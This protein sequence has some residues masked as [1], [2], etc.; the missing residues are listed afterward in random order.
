MAS[1]FVQQN[2]DARDFSEDVLE[3]AAVVELLGGYL[4]GPVGRELLAGLRPRTLAGDI[5]RDLELVREAREYAREIGRPSL[6]A[7]ADPRTILA[8]LGIEGLAL[9]AHEI[10]ALLEL[11]RTARDLRG[12]FRETPFRSLDALAGSLADFRS[13]VASLDGKIL[14]DGTL[15]SSASP[16]LGRLRRAIERL[17]HEVQATLEKLLRRLAQDEVVQDAVVTLRNDRF[18]I[19]IRTE[20]KRRVSGVVHGASSSGATVFIEP[21]ETLPLNNELVELQD[22]ELAEIAR[23]LGEFTRLLAARRAEL[24][25]ATRILSELDLAFAKAEFA[26]AYDCCLPEFVSERALYLKDVRHPLLERTLRARHR[27]PV[28]LTLELAAPKTQMIISG[29]NTGGKTVAVKTVG[30][31]VLMAQAALPVPSSEARLPIFGRVLADIGDQQSIEANL[32]T[33]SAHVRN[34]Q[35]MVEAAEADDLVLLDEIGASTEP[36]EGAALAVSILEHFREKRAM[37]FVTTH[38]SR[39]KAYAAENPETVNAAMEFDE[40]T[41]EPTYRLL[42]GLPGKSS[43]IDTAERLGLDR[44]IVARARDLLD[45]LDAE[46]AALVASLHQQKTDLDQ[47]AASLSREHEKL[48]TE[49][50]QM[51]EQFTRERR[52]RLAELDARLES[53]LREYNAKWEMRLAEIRKV[54][55]ASA[56]VEQAIKKTERKAPQLAQE[57]RESWNEQVLDALGAPAEEEPGT[58]RAPAVGDRVRVSK[59]STPGRIVSLVGDNEVEVEVGRIRMRVPRNEIRVLAKETPA[60]KHLHRQRGPASQL[61]EPVPEAPAEINVIGTTAEEARE[62]VDKFLDDAYLA[63]RFRLRVVHGHGKGILRKSLHEMFAAH[64]H[65]EKFY[66]A[67]QSEG[68][69]G[70]TIVELRL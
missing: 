32:S 57:A 41:L 28:P 69:T 64:P 61:D 20:A 56:Q 58:D 53:T 25:A 50:R 22:R 35:A 45:P 46:S 66:A 47:Q 9:T 48:E 44:G 18:V 8:K 33:F 2:P 36:G 38:H 60:D 12:V 1:E 37:T 6:S 54:S 68:G 39:L 15:D 13:P 40:A 17:R 67:P 62:R 24:D 4:S 49:R 26:R 5:R 27:R 21:L 16:E 52:A 34:I 42:I 11:A 29:P 51:E 7:L 59:I 63:R 65:V 23:L 30:I 14:P 70:A 10:L 19:P 3:F 55:A 31:A 43:G